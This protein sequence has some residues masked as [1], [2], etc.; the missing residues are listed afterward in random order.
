MQKPETAKEIILSLTE[1]FRPEKAEPGYETTFHLDISGERGGQYTVN[2][3]DRKIDVQ[4]GLN[5]T[6]KCIVRAKDEV[7]EDVE[8]E[9]TNPQMAFMLG[10]IK[11]SDIGEML[12]FASLFHRCPQFYK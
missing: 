3:Q 1:R 11:V 8:W 6:A 4:E 10:K 9:R 2:I 7:Y 5:G 12:D